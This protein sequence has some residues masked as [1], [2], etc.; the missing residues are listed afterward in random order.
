MATS[1]SRRG[2]LLVDTSV[3]VAL[4]VADHSA[5]DAVI[6]ALRGRRL[7]LSGHAYFETHS[8]LTRLPGTARRGP[9][10]VARLL[11]HNFP[12][13]RFLAA[14][15]AARL[16]KRLGSLQIAGGSVYDA[17]VGEAAARSGLALA[18]RDQRALDIYRT[19]D[20]EVRLISA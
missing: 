16:A 7:G 18:T 20:V 14:D 3:A 11:E 9:I 8:V 6:A 13:S 4:V 17:L 12:E 5:H 2:P 19:L 10:E 1:G 15:D